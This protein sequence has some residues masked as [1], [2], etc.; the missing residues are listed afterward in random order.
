M[1]NNYFDLFEIYPGIFNDQTALKATYYTLLKKHHP[2]N[3]VNQDN[4]SEQTATAAMIN[5]AYQT[6]TNPLSAAIYMLALEGIT[7]KDNTQPLSPE[8]L[9]EQFMLRERMQ[10]N[11]LTVIPEVEA[12]IKSLQQDFMACMSQ[13]PKDLAQAKTLVQQM[14]Y[15]EKLL[16]G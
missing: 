8:F 7:L 16:K 11:D 15:Y 10:E 3:F 14:Q 12:K 2:D 13:S 5:Q 1:N 9:A 4:S 6:L